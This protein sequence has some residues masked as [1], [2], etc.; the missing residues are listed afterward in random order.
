M[1]GR[2]R[3]RSTDQVGVGVVGESD[4]WGVLGLGTVG[5]Y[6]YGTYGVVGE[7]AVDGAPGS[8][9]SG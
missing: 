2:R 6:G 3:R 5:V 7:S 1:A 8:P 4:D 9:P